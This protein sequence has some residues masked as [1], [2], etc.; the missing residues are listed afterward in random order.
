M[1]LNT[2][3]VFVRDVATARIFYADVLGLQ[4]KV[5]GSSDGFCVFDAGS[6]TLVIEA[7]LSDEPQ[8]VRDLVGRFTGLSFQVPDANAA[9]E[10][11]RSRGVTFSGEPEKQP[12]GGILA[13]FSDP[14]GNE[15]QICEQPSVSSMG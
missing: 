12:W 2:A 9:Y 1:N 13:T 15:L 5:D 14:S 6:C 3:R 4:V 7:V 11:L 8:H 10:R